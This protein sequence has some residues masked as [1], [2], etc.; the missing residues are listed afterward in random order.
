MKR[1]LS[2]AVTSFA[3][4]ACTFTLSPS[5]VAQSM[6]DKWQFQA[7]VYGYLPDIGGKTT[8][9]EGRNGAG[10]VTVDASQILD[11]LN[12]AFMGTFE[13]RKGRWGLFTDLLYMDVSADKNGTR[14]VTVGG[15]NLPAAVSSNLGL[16]LKGTVW[17][18]AG[19][20]RAIA[21]PEGNLDVLAGARLLDLKQSLGFSF[22]GNVG[23]IYG[24]GQTFNSDVDVSYWD[25]IVG[26]K[27]RYAFGAQ[28]QWFVPYYAD[29]GTGDSDLTWQVFGG[30]GYQ[31]S[32]GSVL[33][34][35][36]Y[37]DY[38]FKSS[39]KV[40]S[41]NFNGPMIGVAFNW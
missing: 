19:D 38:D 6:D 12:F 8:F 23:P 22:T 3:L 33:A 24:P 32:W 35:W 20:Y 28:R 9:P 39:S 14:D 4:A 15:G 40:Q 36:R 17:T 41:L 31:F 34:G 13:A 2:I 16:S 29:V 11:N 25:A 1:T 21:T 30:V 37:L 10:G 27:G 5:V 26:V 18:L 7:I